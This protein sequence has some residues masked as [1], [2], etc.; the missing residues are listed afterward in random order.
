LGISFLSQSKTCDLTTF[1][2]ARLTIVLPALPTWVFLNTLGEF[3]IYYS[4]SV[5]SAKKKR[6][7]KGRAFAQAVVNCA[8]SEIKSEIVK[9]KGIKKIKSRKKA[10]ADKWIKLKRVSQ[11]L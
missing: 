6:R 9:I 3:A 2:L 8:G 7:S 11:Q 10:A 1:I 4:S 5:K